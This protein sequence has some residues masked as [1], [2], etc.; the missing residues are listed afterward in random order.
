MLYPSILKKLE[1]Y[2]AYQERS[3][4]DIRL[5]LKLLNVAEESIEEYI[6]YLIEHHYLNEERFACSFA[7]GKHN[8]K[9]WG[10]HG[11]LMS[12]NYT[13]YLI[14]ISKQLLTK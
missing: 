13:E 12:L 14:T 10:K 9:K 5:K 2:C 8:Y 6:V 7:R 3:H 1:S 11:L 4:R